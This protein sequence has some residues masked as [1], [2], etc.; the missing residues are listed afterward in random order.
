MVSNNLIFKFN[1][2]PNGCIVSTLRNILCDDKLDTPHKGYTY[3]I[4]KHMPSLFGSLFHIVLTSGI[5]ISLL[6]LYYF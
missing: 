1:E 5:I 6:K 3:Y 4:D 2:K